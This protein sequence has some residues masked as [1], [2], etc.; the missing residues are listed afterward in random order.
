MNKRAKSKNREPL[1]KSP[2]KRGDEVVIITGSERGKRGK[3]LKVLR[4]SH[5]VIVEG[6]KMVKKAV[7]PSQDNPKGGIVE[8]EATIA[9][10]NVML[11]S[12]WEKRQEKKKVA[13]EKKEQE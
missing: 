5:K 6:I 2:V 9:I 3:V 11:A 10:S 7:R 8:K 12:K 4:N 13:V 1:R